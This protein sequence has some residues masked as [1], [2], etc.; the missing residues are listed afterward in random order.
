MKTLFSKTDS[1]AVYESLLGNSP[2]EFGSSVPRFAVIGKDRTFYLGIGGY[3]KAT[4]GYDFGHVQDNP[5]EFFTSEIPMSQRKGNG[6]KVQFSAQQTSIF[7]NFVGL[8][9]TDNQIGAFIGANLLGDD[10]A[11]ALQYAYLKYRGITA[12]YDKTLFSDPAATPPTIDYEGP[13]AST[14]VNNIV[15]NYRIDFGKKKQW[16]AGVG[17]EMPMMS[18]TDADT[19]D[20]AARPF[21]AYKVNQRVPDIPAFVQFSWADR[22]SWIRLS[23][24][25]RN[26]LYRNV[27][28][29]RNIDKVGWGVQLSGVIVPVSGLTFYYQGVYGEGIASYIQDMNGFGMDML[30]ADGSPYS[31]KRTRSW[32]AYGGIQYDFSEKVF[33]SATYSHVR[34]YADGCVMPSAESGQYD[35]AQYIDANVFWNITNIFQ[36]G[37]EYIY[38]RRVN[39]DGTQAHDSRLQLALQLSF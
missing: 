28:A 29:D 4:V 27:K 31:L 22:S 36:A 13:N 39:F 16:S 25:I 10:Y 6:G 30:P 37:V 32:G 24:V 35:Y 17:V 38:G 20:D 12:G 1:V 21:A 19:Y 11:P 33:A 26:M 18:V 15:L 7:L 3:V 2:T 34:N 9:G 23:G 8:P 5:N 14:A